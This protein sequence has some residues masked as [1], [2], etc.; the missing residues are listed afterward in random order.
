MNP[1]VEEEKFNI[2]DIY[3]RERERE[4]ERERERESQKL[5]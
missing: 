1:Q 5:K 4:S 3:K 2:Y